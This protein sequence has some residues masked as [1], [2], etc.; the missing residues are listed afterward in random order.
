MTK[1]RDKKKK[2]KRT[3][4]R[5]AIAREEKTGIVRG[6]RDT[7][8]REQ[9]AEVKLRSSTARETDVSSMKNEIY[10]LPRFYTVISFDASSAVITIAMIFSMEA[11]RSIFDKLNNCPSLDLQFHINCHCSEEEKT[12]FLYIRVDLSHIY[13]VSP[14]I[15]LILN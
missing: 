1:K 8:G 3:K 9:N 14:A 2:K 12:R 7:A 11:E 4:K 6:Y 15:E 5:E 10:K 13:K